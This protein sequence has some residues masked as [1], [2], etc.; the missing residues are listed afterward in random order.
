MRLNRIC[1]SLTI[2]V[3]FGPIF[4]GQTA[5]R[6]PPTKGQADKKVNLH[7]EQAEKLSQTKQYWQ[8]ISEYKLAIQE[9]PQN[10]AFFF[11]LALTQSQVGQNSQA[12]EAYQAALQINPGL[13][14]AEVNLGIVLLHQQS[15]SEALLHFK[16]AQSINPRDFRTNYY[17]GK[18]QELLEKLGEAE[19]NYLVAL[20]LARED[21]DKCE[22]HTSLGSLYLK[23]KAWAEAEKHLLTAR[24]YQGDAASVDLDLAQ[25]YYETGQSKKAL[26]L[27]RSAN[28]SN[29]PEMAELMGRILVEQ[30]DYEAAIKS[31]DLALKYQADPG[32]RQKLSLDLAQLY[33]ELGRTEVAVLLLRDV[34][35]SSQDPKVHFNLGSL[36]LHQH[37]LA[38]AKQEFLKALQLKPDYVECY[39]NLA[40]VFLLQEKYPEA[41]GSLN[42]FKNFRPETAGTYFYLGIAFDKLNDYENAWSNYQKFLELDQGKTDKQGFQAKERMK[43]LEKKIK[44]R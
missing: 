27:L 22:I 14:E 39:S 43:V 41:I 12:I 29:D 44:R 23:K 28:K 7:F 30:K 37:E 34:A 20:E 6:V 40:S 10:E 1:F 32:R 31:F 26:E 3:L 35:K 21:P 42:Q 38:L 18:A 36:Y 16:K 5:Q 17:T 9:D 24:Q 33:H 25:L 2:I 4:R 15:V 19:A 8:A 11:G 13:W